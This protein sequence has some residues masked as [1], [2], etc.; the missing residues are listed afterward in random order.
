MWQLKMDY[1]WSFLLVVA[2]LLIGVMSCLSILE[3]Y[4]RLNNENHEWQWSSFVAPFCICFYIFGY[5]IVYYFR[6]TTMNGMIQTVYFFA[7]T[8][9]FSCV[10]GVVCG[11]VGF[12]SSAI[13]VKNIYK[14]LKTD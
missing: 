5:S 9:I 4:S 1:V 13:F 7:Y 12:I 8:A 11:F 2:L 6:T 10:I 3:T 14:N